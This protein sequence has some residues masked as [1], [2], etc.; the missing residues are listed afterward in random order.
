M[1]RPSPRNSHAIRVR[2]KEFS[3]PPIHDALVLGRKA[4]IGCVA[5]RRAIELLSSHQFDHLEIRD[6]VI[7]NILIRSAILRRISRDRLTEFI[8][9]VIKPYMGPEEI[10]HLDLEAEVWLEE[11][12]P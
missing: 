6:D 11:N 1:R 10:L 9:T 3:I 4:P 8:Q 5:M 7:S 12:L 2:L